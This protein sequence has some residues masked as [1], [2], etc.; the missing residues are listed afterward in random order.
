VRWD[1]PIVLALAG[2][3]AIHI[4]LAVFVDAMVV[5]HPLVIPPPAPRIELFEVKVEPPPKLKPAARPVQARTEPPPPTRTLPK[6]PRPRT[7]EVRTPTPPPETPQS[8]DDS[9]GAP[10]V[11]IDNLAPDARGTV[12][13]IAGRGG[14][15]SVGRG[16]RGTGT[17]AGAGSGNADLP[18]PKPVSIATIK[19]RALPKGD[20]GYIDASRDYPAEA[21]QLGIEGQIRVRLVVDVGGKVAA[22]ALLN[23]LG[24]GLDELALE[25]ARKI[26][27]EPARDTDDKPVSSVVVWTFNM[28]LPKS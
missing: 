4:I 27:F 13:V 8:S 15:K 19:Q 6:Q 5:T 16:G 14:G 11:H 3:A 7:P 10:V 25:R 24:H 26:E 28:V 1:S 9:G 17:G 12:P 23:R 21:R 2:T 18:P 22:A 20:Y